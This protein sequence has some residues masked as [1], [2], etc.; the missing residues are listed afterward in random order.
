MSNMKKSIIKYFAILSA[1]LLVS[2]C[3]WNPPTFD[4]ADSFIAFTAASS[5]IPEQGGV[6]AIPVLVTSVAGQPAVSVTFDFDEASVAIE[7]EDFTLVN[8]S[9]TLEFSNGAGYDTIY[10]Q[11]IDNDI[12]T[13]NIPLIINLTSNTQSY[14]F[15]VTKSHT[16]TIIDNEHPLGNWIGTY[17]V[18]AVDYWSYFG[19]ETWTV[20]TEPDPGDVNNLIVTGMGAGYSEYTSVTGVVDLDAKT[21]TFSAGS[22]IG[23]HAD[24]SGPIA[25][26]LGDEG[27]GIYEEPIVG[28][29]NDDGSI[30]VDHLGVKFVGGL[31][32]GLTWAVFETTW[33]PAKKKAVR[34]NAEAGQVKELKLQP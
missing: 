8:P 17:S 9:N 24:Y 21:I 34:V 5:A 29:I 4:S 11:P 18:D 3:E 25:I 31:N 19:P 26:Y 28:V 30:Y 33:T 10:I 2:S 13:G 16:L 7:G 32:A 23:T 27:G 15:G 1:V 22:E 12:F 14:A 6:I 20:T